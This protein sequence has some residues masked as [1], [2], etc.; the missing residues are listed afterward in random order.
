MLERAL[1]AVIVA[2]SALAGCAQTGPLA[3][4]VLVVVNTDEKDSKAVAAHYMQVRGVPLQ[5][6]CNVKPAGQSS[7]DV[8]A[9]LDWDDFVKTIEDPVRKC[10]D[11]IGRWEIIYIVVS[12][13]TPF[14]LAHQ[15]SEHGW[16][17]DQYL[18]DIW[19]KTGPT[20]REGNPYFGAPRAKLN[21]YPP[22]IALADWRKRP[23]ARPIYSVW[24]L[25]APT[26]ALASALVDKAVAAEQH[27]LK[28]LAC[29]DRRY[30]NV[31]EMEDS[32]MAVGDWELFRAAEF[33]RKAGFNVLE[34]D[35]EAEFGTAPAPS[36]C[37]NVALYSGWYAYN[38][39][40]DAFS[41]AEGAVGIHLDSAS[42]ANPRSGANWAANA[43]LRG[44]TVTGGAVAEPYLVGLPRPDVI[45]RCLFEGANVGD[46]FLRG[47]AWLKWQI[48]YIGDPLYRPFPSGRPPFAL[49]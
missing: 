30:N 22:F 14:A 18:A 8:T 46:A 42:V 43:L 28:G 45:F 2:F 36:R 37:D 29:I 33:A 27:G 40:N 10:L 13:K 6:R 1:L 21:L 39:Y 25:D 44:I 20:G 15:P 49:K 48:T 5:N 34:D 11:R 9:R 31:R 23:D 7:D 41:W 35:H 24:R 12:Y 32:G 16:A 17:I 4:H 26:A 47:T 3:S 19:D 38:H